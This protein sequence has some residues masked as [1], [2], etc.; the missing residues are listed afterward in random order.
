MKRLLGSAL[1]V[2]LTASSVVACGSSTGSGADPAAGSTITVGVMADMTGAYSSDF[3]TAAKGIQARLDLQN[4]QGG[5]NGHKLSYVVADTTSSEAGTLSAAQ[6]LV[7]N[8]KAFAVI[9]DN[10]DGSAAVNFLHQQNVPYIAEGSSAPQFGEAAYTNMFSVTGSYNPHYAVATTYGDFF[11]KEGVTSVAGVGYPDAASANAVKAHLAGASAAGLKVSY[12]DT[13]LPIGSTDVGAIALGIQK[14]GAN[15]I[16]LPILPN[17]AFALLGQLKQLGVTIKA[18][19]VLTGYGED[20]LGSPPAVQAAQGDDFTSFLAPLELGTP[21]TR[22]VLDA[23][24]KYSGITTEPT[25]A[26]YYGWL[27]ADAFIAGLKAAPK[28]P[29]RQQYITALRGIHDYDAG[30]LYTGATLNFSQIGN[31][32]VG[33]GPGNCIYIVKLQGNAFHPV[34]GATP[35]CGKLTGQTVG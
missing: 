15:G 13:S 32:S 22:T 3:A 25:S 35:I 29:S 12:T 18:A 14:S 20:L 26:E 11:R 17:T 8:D 31:V 19:V 34:P 10:A 4:A 16:F 30:G 24:R 1:L 28:N 5:V 21:A 23:M 2:A 9:G 7:Q 27:L 6:T 33:T